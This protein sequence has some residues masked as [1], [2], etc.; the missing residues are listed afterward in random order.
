MQS[1]SP[2]RI[3][4]DSLEVRKWECSQC[5]AIHIRDENAGMNGLRKVLKDF[6]KKMKE[7]ILQ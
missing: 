4:R 7:N 2:C 1:V 6:S 5:Q 3:I